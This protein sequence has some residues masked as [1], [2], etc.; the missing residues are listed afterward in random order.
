MNV[1]RPKAGQPQPNKDRDAQGRFPGNPGGPENPIA[2]KM[3]EF[4]LLM[5]ERVSEDDFRRVMDA[6]IAK[7]AEGNLEAIKLLFSYA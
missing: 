7:A 6:L 2:R 1:E 5:L 4:R 3:A